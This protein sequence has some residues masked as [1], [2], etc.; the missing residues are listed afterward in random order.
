VT[1]HLHSRAAR[2]TGSLKVADGGAPKIMYQPTGYARILAPLGP[3]STKVFDTSAIG[4]NKHPRD[5]A[6]VFALDR[7]DHF[8]LCLE[9]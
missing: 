9:D 8:P 7:L 5:D 2:Y 1:R 4:V 6:R 3:S